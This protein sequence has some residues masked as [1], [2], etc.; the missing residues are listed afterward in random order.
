MPKTKKLLLALIIPF[1]SFSI[2]TPNLEMVWPIPR[3]E[4]LAEHVLNLN[5]RLPD[6]DFGNE[7]FKYNI[8]LA[9]KYI[10]GNTNLPDSFTAEVEL[11]PGE[12]F[13]FQENLLPEFENKT[14]KTGWTKYIAEEGYKP[15]AGLYG[16]G[17][18]HL[19]SLI[20]WVGSDAGLKVTAPAN[21]NFWPVPGVPKEYGTS[22]RYLADG[23]WKTK[24]Q[25]LYLENPF[26]YSVK[27]IFEASNEEVDLRVVR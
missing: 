16:N 13:A 24:N 25:N 3:E 15:L 11:Q 1:F 17:V 20:N 2:P 6:S 10:E 26:D 21:H 19:A 4:V 18:C 9:L 12:V 14:V 5:E 23:S 7:V 8:L 22:I 27:L